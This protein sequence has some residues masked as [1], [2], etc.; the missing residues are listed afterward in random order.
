[1]PKTNSWSLWRGEDPHSA[2]RSL[3]EEELMPRVKNA[4]VFIVGCHRSGTSFLYHSILS[5]GGFAVYRCE[6]AVWDRL[7]PLCGDLA[8]A[9]NRRRMVQVWLRS[10]MFRRTG[11]DARQIEAKILAECRSGGQF[12]RMVMEEVART[13]HV[14]RWAAWSPENTFYMAKIKKEIPDALFIHILR[15]GRDVATV[16]DKKA[17]VKPFPWDRKSS[18]LAAGA[19]WAWMV[20]AGIGGGQIVG[21]DYMEIRYENLLGQP[22]ET[23]A[24]IGRFIGHELDYD[25]IQASGIGTVADPNSTYREEMREGQFSPIGRW[26]K[27][28]SIAQIKRLE[29]LIGP[30]LD[31]L[32]YPRAALNGASAPSL[33]LALRSALYSKYFTAKVWLKSNTLAGR[34]ASKQPLELTGQFV[35]TN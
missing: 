5:S 29:H 18:L 28:L 13:Q 34:L 32:G 33:G 24:R 2:Q 19:Y 1:M 26:E 20:R 3:N 11:L 6:T 17:W 21:R 23:L 22:R 30:L 31:E 7:L 12:L 10:K 35:D 9:E 15:D 16:L 25:R 14:N 4:P 27:A 8:Q